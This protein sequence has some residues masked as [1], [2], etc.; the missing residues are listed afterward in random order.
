MTTINSYED[1]I[2]VGGVPRS[3]TTLLQNMLDSHPDVYGGPEF[4]HLPSIIELRRTMHKSVLSGAIARYT[5]TDEIDI[6]LRS[7]AISF[8]SRPARESGANRISEKTPGNALCFDEILDLFPFSVGVHVVR[9]PR[10]ILASMRRVRS[11]YLEKSMELPQRIRTCQDM[12]NTI[13]L[14]FM[15]GLKAFKKNP[16]R[17]I[18]IRFEDLVTEPLIVMKKLCRLAQ[19]NFCH[20]MLRPSSNRHDAES[21][22]KAMTPWY[23]IDEFYRDPDPSQIEAWKNYINHDHLEMLIQAFGSDRDQLLQY[24]YDFD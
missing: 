1:L 16:A 9:D 19:I 14:Y 15:C 17:I 7:L 6:N 4:G 5:T 21:L 11:R 18:V 20:K 22:V 10:A 2:V 12:A 3:G 23:T 13:A 8:L 24:R